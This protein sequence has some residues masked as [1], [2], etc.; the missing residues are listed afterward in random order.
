MRKVCALCERIL[1][2]RDVRPG[3]NFL[4]LG[5]D[6]ITAMKLAAACR[7]EGITVRSVRF[8]TADSLADMFSLTPVDDG[9]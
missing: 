3:D 9:R 6:S 2:V 1:G 5:G 7:R 4:D 8:L